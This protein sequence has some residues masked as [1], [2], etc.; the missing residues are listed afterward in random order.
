MAVIGYAHIPWESF[1]LTQLG[2][3]QLGG[4]LTRPSSIHIVGSPYVGPLGAAGALLTAI[5]FRQLKP[6]LRML[7]L[8]FA[9]IG[10]YGLLSGLGTNLGMAY[11]NFHLPFINHIREAGRHLVL[12]VIGVSFLSGL[13]YSLLAQRLKQYKEERGKY[14]R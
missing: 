6:F 7:L 1:N 9:I 14:L 8:S 12:L 2:L 4:I 5:Y 3:S 13:G 11:V 10:S